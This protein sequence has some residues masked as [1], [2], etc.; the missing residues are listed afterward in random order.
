MTNLQK[1][2]AALRSGEYKQ[3]R[4]YLRDG[5]EYCCLGVLCDVYRKETGKGEW[6]PR[7]NNP[8]ETYVFVVD[9]DTSYLVPNMAVLDWL[10]IGE[11][12]KHDFYAN[13]SITTLNDDLCWSFNKIADVLEALPL[14]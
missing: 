10:C 6:E 7:F 8:K 9:G 3:G 4:S 13:Y 5:A 1:W 12:L 14:E 11:L 2:I